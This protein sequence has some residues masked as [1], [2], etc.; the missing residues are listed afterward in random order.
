M[1]KTYILIHKIYQPNH[2]TKL[3]ASS[4]SEPTLRYA[5]F[6]LR[7]S[8]V[9]RSPH[10]SGNKNGKVKNIASNSFEYT[11]FRIQMFYTHIQRIENL[12][13][14]SK[15]AFMNE[16]YKSQTFLKTGKS[17]KQ[18]IRENRLMLATTPSFHLGSAHQR[19]I[20]WLTQKHFTIC[21]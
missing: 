8:I 19:R 9:V 15:M 6:V 1:P 5:S 4:W 3:W 20:M 10:L 2:K 7:F 12:H 13:I 11:S 14:R 16:V 17:L 18:L 21:N